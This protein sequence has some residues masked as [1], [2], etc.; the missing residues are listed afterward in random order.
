MRDQI[1]VT[2]ASGLLGHLLVRRLREAGR[3]VRATSRHPR[4]AGADPGLTWARADLRAGTGVREAVAGAGAIVHCA[5]ASGRRSEVELA[6]TLVE[7]ARDAGSPHLLYV[8]IVGVDRVP[9]G[10]YQG[11]LAAERLVERSG[12]PYTILRATQFHDLLRVVLARAAAVPVMPVPDL[13]FQPVDAG[14]VA[15]RLAEL[16]L[17]DPA[18]RAPDLAGPEVRH[19]RDLA[20]AYLAATG[21]RR[22]M[23]PVRLPGR[24]FRAFRAGGH[25]AP[26]HATGRV[27]FEEHLARFAGLRS[28]RETR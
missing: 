8:S 20:R 28:Y 19:T 24:T 27:T 4:P 21:R 18:G 25:L 2:G 16:A 23:V 13:R 15:D 17:G 3:P 5:T 11:K 14:E 6:R 22:P 12:L 7:A 10:Y 1:L 9:L 26:E